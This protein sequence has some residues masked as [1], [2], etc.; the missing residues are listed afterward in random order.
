VYM[1]I[2]ALEK[3]TPGTLLLLR[4]VFGLTFFLHGAQKLLG[5]FDGPGIEGVTGFVGSLGFAPAAF[6]AW[7]LALVEFVG[8]LLLI[9]GLLTQIVAL[10]IAVDMVIAIAKVH[11]ANGFFVGA[12]GYE[13]T[14]LLLVVGLFFA[15]YGG[16]KWALD[17]VLHKNKSITDSAVSSPPQAE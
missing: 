3:F 6:W 8:G 13:L 9:L 12:G 1:R 16:G 5:W 10:L 7:A 17:R 2:K 14:L 11:L 4:V 15:T